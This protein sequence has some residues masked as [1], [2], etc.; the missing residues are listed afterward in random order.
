MNRLK[1]MLAAAVMAA[2]TLMAEMATA[3]TVMAKEMYVFG[4]A[5]SFTDSIVH[6]TDIQRVDSAWTDSKSGFLLGRETYSYQLRSYLANKLNQPNRTCITV[7][8]TKR[9]KIEKKYL[10]MMR[11]YSEQKG[12]KGIPVKG[13]DVHHINQN[14]F[15]YAAVDMSQYDETA[16]K[17]TKKKE[18]KEKKQK[19]GDNRHRDGMRPDRPGNA[20]MLPMGGPD[21]G[22]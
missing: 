20:G 19:A 1:Y 16:M 10:K 14:Q 8:A 11:Q 2:G 3:K 18:R 12:K 21:S 17:E 4:F 15:K 22:Q 5:A 7:F 9:N 13:F 6:F